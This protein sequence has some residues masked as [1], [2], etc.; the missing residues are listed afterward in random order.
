MQATT[1]DDLATLLE[2]LPLG[3]TLT[4]TPGEY[5]VGTLRVVGRTV[6]AS[7]RG[8]IF[9][10]RVVLADGA[11]LVGVSVMG[12][13]EANAVICNRGQATL[14]YCTVRIP[15]VSTY[16]AVGV[17]DAQLNVVNSDVR[18]SDA[19]KAI[20][21]AQNAQIAVERSHTDALEILSNVSA[22][23]ASST[24]GT[25][26][27][28]KGGRA[29]LGEGVA[30]KTP[31]GKR[32][33]AVAGG[34]VL[35]GQRAHVDTSRP[36]IFVKDAT[37]RIPQ[38]SS[39]TGEHITVKASG[40]A[41]V[42]VDQSS[43]VVERESADETEV[44]WSASEGADFDRVV[45]PR[46]A[47]EATVILEAGEYRMQSVPEKMRHFTI[48]G[49]GRDETTIAVTG[50]LCAKNGGTV[51]I[52]DAT[53]LQA[54]GQNCFNVFDQSFGELVRTRVVT[55]Q[56]SSNMPAIFARGR[57][58]LL[59]DAIVESP[60]GVTN[61]TLS[62][63]GGELVAKRSFLGWSQ[64]LDGVL[65]VFEN[66]RAFSI[67][68][69]NSRLSGSLVLHPSMA[70]FRQLVLQNGSR[71]E[72]DELTLFA[73]YGEFLVNG[74]VLSVEDTK[75]TQGAQIAI[76]SQNGS[77]VD[78]DVAA[79]FE[80]V[81]GQWKQVQAPTPVNGPTSANS[82][83]SGQVSGSSQGSGAAGAVA[84]A[85]GDP[86]AQINELIGLASVKRQIA[87][88]MDRVKFNQRRNELGLASEPVVMH[89]MFLGNPGTGKTTVAR[90]LGQALYSAGA[91]RT[92]TFVEV[93]RAD[94][95]AEHIGGTAQKTNKVLEEARGGVLFVDEAYDLHSEGGNDF[96]KEAVNAILT[97]MENNREDI[98]IIFAGYTDKM[99]DFLSMNPGLKS[100]IPNRF[101]FEDYSAD[102]LAQIG[103]ASL[104]KKGYTFD[105]EALHSAIRRQ[106][107]RSGDGSNGR[108]ARNF[109]DKL[110][111][112]ISSRL[113]REYA[114]DLSKVTNEEITSVT[115]AD[116]RAVSGGE[117]SGQRVEELL[118]QLESLIG[119]E[120]V[121]QWAA[122]LVRV[123]ETN[124]RLEAQ[125]LQTSS[126]TYHMVF[127]GNPGT[128]KTTVARIVAEIF[129]ALGILESPTV[130]EVT[131]SDLVGSVIG[132]TEKQTTRALDEALGGVLF[133]DEAYQLT[134]AG[135]ANDFGLQAVETLL[136]RLENDRSK[137]IAILAGYTKEMDEFMNANPGLRSRIPNSIEF[138]DYSPVD[139]ARIVEA[140]I[141]G[142]GWLVDADLLTATVVAAYEALPPAER[143]NGRW[144]RNFADRLEH[145][146]K[147]WI[148]QNNVSGEE[149]RRI[150]DDTVRAVAG[151]GE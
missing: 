120:E 66:T 131:R 60:A 136:P 100:R 90:L 9:H 94:L 72:F 47:P 89:S 88:F 127:S 57:R 84:S 91:V 140:S 55:A 106:Y 34:G 56:R 104:A 138:P 114:G 126:P 80:S 43:C 107:R 108:W 26:I 35:E 15:A 98:V 6:Q 97:F 81:D 144:A 148:S 33:A 7:G 3:G 115:D 27:I 78:V 18:G 125:G 65:A 69:E 63:S 38:M 113:A 99:Q 44:R 145:Q 93:G 68:A 61:A 25:L 121:K 48:R 147:L 71:G 13:N 8:V 142:R 59:E 101:D 11:A 132:A 135:G 20:L 118:D 119:L 45:A 19:K 67:M 129:H 39:Q 1:H 133:I 86:M 40:G 117:S 82:G 110:I 2:Q 75:L 96:G 17:K 12:P 150:S 29:H 10:G 122:E 87:S 102:E 85:P 64:I 16:P 49:A 41:T 123:A 5:S 111:S 58:L 32:I 124:Q 62:V 105:E 52:E 103:A 70:N 130:K 74:S 51:R 112:S 14:S 146:H 46:L 137:F 79:V 92:N 28:N 139:V 50:A 151:I 143:S 36:E 24:V 141:T 42:D 134:A 4:V 73:S 83:K 95:V 31:A 54:D 37:V 109:E 30:I 128:G 76:Y 77:Q 21:G 23:I 22:T 116:I 149:L 53:I